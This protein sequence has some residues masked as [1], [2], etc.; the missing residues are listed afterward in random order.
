MADSATLELARILLAC[1]KAGVPRFKPDGS[2]YS[3]LESVEILASR[4]ETFVPP[5]FQPEPVFQQPL[6]RRKPMKKANRASR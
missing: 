2:P 6:K 5:E 1:R 3:V 4:A